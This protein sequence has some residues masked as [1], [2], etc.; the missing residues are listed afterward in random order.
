MGIFCGI[1]AGLG[2][3]QEIWAD[4][5]YSL[6]H[7]LNLGSVHVGNLVSVAAQVSETKH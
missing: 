4:F 6:L 5:A 1:G 3:F 7:L 2:C